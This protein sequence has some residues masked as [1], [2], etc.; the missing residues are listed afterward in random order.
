MMGVLRSDL[1]SADL[2][3]YLAKLCPL[4][5]HDASR[6]RKCASCD[7]RNRIASD[8]AAPMEH[9]NCTVAAKTYT[10]EAAPRVIR[11]TALSAALLVEADLIS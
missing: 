7:C 4:H 1:W 3:L 11:L 6:A 8:F 2:T 10:H 5:A 9:E